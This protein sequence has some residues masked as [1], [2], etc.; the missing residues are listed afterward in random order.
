MPSLCGE[1]LPSLCGIGGSH[2][3]V[4]WEGVSPSLWGGRGSF[5]CRE[6]GV[7]L[8]CRWRLSDYEFVSLFLIEDGSPVVVDCGVFAGRLGSST[9]GDG[10]FWEGTRVTSLSEDWGLSLQGNEVLM[11][12]GIR[13]SSLCGEERLLCTRLRGP[14]FNGNWGFPV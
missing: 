13:G 4:R 5:L 3:C 11:C 10:V 14:H 2:T 6:L 7:Y 9:F 12:L 1:E 8:W